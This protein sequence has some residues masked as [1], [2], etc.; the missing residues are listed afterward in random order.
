M[1]NVNPY[2]ERARTFQ[3]N[4][5]DGTFVLGHMEVTHRYETPEDPTFLHDKSLGA[6]VLRTAGW[7]GEKTRTVLYHA[8]NPEQ[9]ARITDAFVRGRG[10]S[11]NNIP[12]QFEP[13][14]GDLPEDLAGIGEQSVE[15]Y[16]S[17]RS[18][19]DRIK[20]VMLSTL[21]LWV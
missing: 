7:A 13:V 10:Y 14:A 1:T 3:L 15:R 4:E 6:K 12:V 21:F 18:K 9:A 20:R 17:I 2:V 5:Q 11:I 19:S 16:R 8:E